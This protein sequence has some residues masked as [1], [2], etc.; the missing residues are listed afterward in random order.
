MVATA[1]YIDQAVFLFLYTFML[2]M[3]ILQLAVGHRITSLEKEEK[4]RAYRI[5]YKTSNVRGN[6]MRVLKVGKLQYFFHRIGFLVALLQC[7]RY[8]DPY[9]AYDLYGQRAIVFYFY[10][11]VAL[12]I[13]AF[14]GAFYL[15]IDL[16]YV[17]SFHK[18]PPP[19]YR[20]S[21]YG[22][23]VLAFLGAELCLITM[24]NWMAGLYY[25]IIA[26]VMVTNTALFDVGMFKLNKAIARLRDKAFPSSPRS[27]NTSTVS[28]KSDTSATSSATS[29]G[30]DALGRALRHMMYFAIISNLATVVAVAVE[31]SIAIGLITKDPGDEVA[32][33][34]P[35][36][37]TFSN[38]LI[39]VIL[40]WLGLVVM[41]W[42]SYLPIDTLWKTSEE[43]ENST[44][45]STAPTQTHHTR[46]PS[47]PK[48]RPMSHKPNNGSASTELEQIPEPIR[49]SSLD[50]E[51]MLN[52]APTS[53][54]VD[55]V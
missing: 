7:L 34:D 2:V 33:R 1:Y 50:D 45:N 11:I 43:V 44:E 9:G 49:A 25:L 24:A 52:A 13:T 22:S 15:P 6:K 30:G 54:T 28:A 27:N 10:N 37:Y 40:V 21:F 19:S 17:V 55:Q 26:V 29:T 38:T 47:S 20:Y 5:S 46:A 3:F 36:K 4:K 23:A 16:I 31:I 35:E 8:I 42:Y 39:G 32:L 53:S 48:S 12:L 41:L 14:A 51:P 18:S